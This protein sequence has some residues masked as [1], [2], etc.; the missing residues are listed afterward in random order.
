MR[1]V[2]PGS[3]LGSTIRLP[4]TKKTRVEDVEDEE[5]VAGPS[6]VRVACK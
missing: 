6:M 3:G 1:R 4:L 2:W 5:E